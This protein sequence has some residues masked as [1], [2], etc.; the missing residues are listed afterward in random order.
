MTTTEVETVQ[1]RLRQF[2]ALLQKNG[3]QER[4]E[5]SIP[6]GQNR[7]ETTLSRLDLEIKKYLQEEIVITVIH[8]RFQNVPD[9]LSRMT[10]VTEDFLDNQYLDQL[11]IAL[12]TVQDDA[13]AALGRATIP[14][15]ASGFSQRGAGALFLLAYNLKDPIDGTPVFDMP[16]EIVNEHDKHY[17]ELP[18]D[19][20]AT[21]CRNMIIRAVI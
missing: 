13:L 1:S 9:I 3:E 16:E 14:M 17:T 19:V 20:A 6:V 5:P 7:T 11:A 4:V 12:D 2:S 21:R 15:I 10:P 8:P 18:E